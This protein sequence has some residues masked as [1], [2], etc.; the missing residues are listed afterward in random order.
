MM[1]GVHP[2][3]NRIVEKSRVYECILPWARV[4]SYEITPQAVVRCVAL[5][6]CVHPIIS[7]TRLLFTFTSFTIA[8]T[9]IQPW[10]HCVCWRVKRGG[11]ITD[12]EIRGDM[13][14]QASTKRNVRGR[15]CSSKHRMASRIQLWCHCICRRVKIGGSTTDVKI[16]GV[17]GWQTST[18]RNVQR[19]R[20]RRQNTNVE[21]N[22]MQQM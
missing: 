11:S 22:I 19:V 16:Q 4:I 6:A 15:I 13:G 21:I 2:S 8:S 7:F 9:H 17:M 18:K 5:A 14:W 1:E 20:E 12:V 10:H 3:P